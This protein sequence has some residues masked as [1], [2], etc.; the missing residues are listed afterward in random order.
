[1]QA[2][3]VQ[4]PESALPRS[5]PTIPLLRR[6]LSLSADERRGRSEGPRVITGHRPSSPLTAPPRARRLGPDSYF[7]SGAEHVELQRV[8]R[9]PDLSDRD[10]HQHLLQYRVAAVIIITFLRVPQLHD[11]DFP[12]TPSRQRRGVL[13]A[14][15]PQFRNHIVAPVR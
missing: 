12:S 5:T 9:Q 14:P 1:M 3:L 11:R 10:S 2:A 4:Q 6:L 7:R 13:E 8:S 15:L